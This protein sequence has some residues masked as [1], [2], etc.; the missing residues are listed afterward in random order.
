M[1]GERMTVCGTK[2]KSDINFPLDIPHE[3]ETQY[4]IG[5]FFRLLSEL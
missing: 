3:T 2:I 4:K 5:T 1:G